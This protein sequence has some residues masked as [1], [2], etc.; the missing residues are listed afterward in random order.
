LI[1]QAASATSSIYADVDALLKQRERPTAIITQGTYTLGST[2]RAI[3]DN[4]LRIPRD[5][6][7]VTLGE[8]D[9]AR[10]HRPGISVLSV[11]LRRT[12][13]QVAALLHSRMAQPQL[14]A[15]TEKVPLVFTDRGSIGH[16]PA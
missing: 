4:G 10:D 3:A 11:E 16:P 6:S 14:A 2:L 8:T 13:E 7:V 1:V 9:V 15:R 5:I 12:A